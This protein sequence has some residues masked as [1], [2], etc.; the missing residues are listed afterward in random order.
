MPYK[1]TPQPRRGGTSYP[2]KGE[3]RTGTTYPKKKKKAK[4]KK[5][6]YSGVLGQVNLRR[7]KAAG[8]VR[9]VNKYK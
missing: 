6:Q 9:K 3:K 4:K 8:T 1:S 2:K 7:E 5:S